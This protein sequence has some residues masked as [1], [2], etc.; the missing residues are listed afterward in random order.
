MKLLGRE[1]LDKLRGLGDQ[2]QKWIQSW[3]NEVTTANWKHEAEVKDQFP[4]VHSSDQGAF[5]FPVAG[6][7]W[8]IC[9]LIAYPQ[10]VA[11]I[12][13]LKIEDETFGS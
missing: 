5:V 10:G 7:G 9:L 3:A 12:T 8:K 2:V 4:N 6:C 13:E 11:L 1:R